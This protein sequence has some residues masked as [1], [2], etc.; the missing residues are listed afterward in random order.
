MASLF[1]QSVVLCESDSDCK[2]YSIIENHLMQ[3]AG[4][5][6][7]TLFVHCGGKHRISK[8]VTA[9]R[10]LG[11]NVKII[12][13]IDVLNDESVF[14]GITNSFGIKWSEIQPYY[15]DVVNNLHSPKERIKRV[16]AKT[17][18]NT[19]LDKHK[20]IYVSNNDLSEIEGAI[21]TI[22]K[23]TP[24]KKGGISVLPSGNATNSFKHIDQILQDN[25]FYIVP[26]G[27]L[28]CF[29]KE[30][31]GHGPDWVNTVLEKHPDLNDVVYDKIKSFISNLS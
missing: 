2:L 12:A 31:G 28:E 22:S 25:G 11:I 23:W 30:V 1:H 9:L 7:E 19:I 24:L 29:I 8:I 6:S 3:E 16:D 13:D 17:I 4:R 18:I 15:S 14:K 10:S 26:V 21:K 5:Y 27:E 20:D